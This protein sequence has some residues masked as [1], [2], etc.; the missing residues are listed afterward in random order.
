MQAVAA[1][2]TS[3]GRAR[4]GTRLLS[5][6]HEAALVGEDHGLSK[7]TACRQGLAVTAKRRPYGA[8][9]GPGRAGER[10]RPAVSRS[11]GEAGFQGQDPLQRGLERGLAQG[12]VLIAVLQRDF[13]LVTLGGLLRR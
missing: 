2:A 3:A 6:A 4:P 1:K 8:G 7:A 9:T 13:R 12:S 5:G 10:Q 11:F